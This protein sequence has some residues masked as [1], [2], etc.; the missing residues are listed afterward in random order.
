MAPVHGNYTRD[1]QGGKKK[2]EQNICLLSKIIK[3][4]EK[5]PKQ[6]KNF[7][8]YKHLSPS[9]CTHEAKCDGV[10]NHAT[11]PTQA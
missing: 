1:M 10:P 5:N 6:K 11:P 2:R 4:R 8:K 3:I 9:K 7:K